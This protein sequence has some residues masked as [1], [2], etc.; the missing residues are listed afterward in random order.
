L[1]RLFPYFQKRI[2][3]VSSVPLPPLPPVYQTWSV[4]AVD[5]FVCAVKTLLPFR[6]ISYEVVK[7]RLPIHANCRAS[8]LLRRVLAPSSPYLAVLARRS[9]R[10]S[11]HPSRSPRLHKSLIS[12]ISIGTPLGESK[13]FIEPSSPIPAEPLGTQNWWR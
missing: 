1:I 2:S 9:L 6:T 13:T 5:G 11:L 10:V 7:Y 8:R 4:R 12:Q 3:R